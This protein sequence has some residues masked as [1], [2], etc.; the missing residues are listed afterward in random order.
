MGSTRLWGRQVAALTTTVIL[1]LALTTGCGAGADTKE[2]AR[3]KAEDVNVNQVQAY[4]GFAARMT[5]QL[6]QE[7]GEANVVISP[8]SVTLAL[9]LAL[10]GADGA[11]KQ[12][13]LHMLGV[14]K[15]SMEALNQGSEVL[16]DLLEHGDPQVDVEIANALWARKGTQLLETY[17][18]QI[19]QSY[20]AKVSELDFDDK[21][22][23]GTINKWVR[24]QTHDRIDKMVNPDTLRSSVMILMNAIYFNGKWTKP[25]EES[26]THDAQF[27]LADGTDVT[28][29]MMR[30]RTALTY[31]ESKQFKAVR[32]PYG[33]GR[34]GMIVVLPNEGIKLP[35][36]EAELLADT[37]ESW[38]KDFEEGSVSI[39]LPRFKLEY[40]KSLVDTLQAL[41]MKQAFSPKTADFSAM[42]DPSNNLYVSGI[43]HKSFIE[44][45]ESG[46][47]AAAVTGLQFSGSAEPPKETFEFRVDRPFFFAIED[48]TTGALVFLGSVW[49][50]VK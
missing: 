25:F 44:V 4:N 13:I 1:A 7:S 33:S 38:R 26:A 18:D 46:T 27:H 50:P 2:A 28:V 21:D 41:G 37:S 3:Y 11:T 15:I 34:W 40:E 49:N 9:S 43:L 10:N 29:P 48:R 42:T 39:E 47:E 45:N 16:T 30:Q 31:K 8:L 12:E 36:V 19:K 24:K 17:A 35:D 5:K 32:L 14:D 22:A 23:A 6:L 20:D